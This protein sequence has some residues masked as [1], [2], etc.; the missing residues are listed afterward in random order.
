MSK[1][2]SIKNIGSKSLDAWLRYIERLHPKSIAMGLD[3][4]KLVID[5]LKLQPNFIIITVAGTN[6]KGSTCAMLE[7]IYKNAGYQV[8]CYTSPHL[9]R[10]N[11][12]VRVNGNQVSDESLCAAFEEIDAARLNANGDLTPLT[13][14]EVGT[15]AAIWHFMQTDIDV[16]ILEIGLGG[17]LDA[18]NAI[19][20]NCAIVTSVDLD[21][22]EFLGNTRESI[23]FEKAGVYR[24]LVPAICG[25]DNPPASLVAHAHEIQAD[26]MCIHQDFDCI[27][28][29]EDL[30]AQD[31][32]RFISGTQAD[33]ETVYTL[34]LPALQGRYQLNNAACA[35]AAVESMQLSLPVGQVS[36]ASAMHQVGLV[37]RFQTI[38]KSPYVILDVAHN[39][40]AARALSENLKAG[41]LHDGKTIAVFAM[42]ADKDVKG[43]VEAVINEIDIWYV[44]SID[45]LRG[46]IATDLAA[47][48]TEVDRHAN[49]KTF[50]HAGNAFQQACIDAS[51][52]DKIIAFGSFFTVSSVMQAINDRTKN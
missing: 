23:G 27:L 33:G 32:W 1:S 50:E 45:H 20:P 5:R 7:Q 30:D 52:N 25:D 14:F 49:V 2:T 3:R 16:A 47:V 26:F 24:T 43:V 15:L 38:S 22:Q 6:G 19:E 44:A 13:Y 36:I 28:D 37:G 21:H 9:L 51:E 41:K 8:G 31:K 4:V 34:P 18:V 29:I 48:V 46:S 17:R 42:L 12:R 35:I 11:E 40:H 10:Y 39:P